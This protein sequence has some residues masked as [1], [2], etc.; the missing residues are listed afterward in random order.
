MDFF[1]VPTATFGVLYVFLVLAHE[2]RKILPF[3]ITEAPSTLWTAQQM[4]E[5]FPDTTPP[6]YLLRDG[7][8]ISGADFVRRAEG[9]GLKQKLISPQSPWQNPTVE[10]L[11]GALRRECL[12]CRIV[13]N[14][15]HLRR[16]L[17]DYVNYYH[18]HRTHRCLDQDCQE[19]R[20]V[21]SPEQGKV[22]EL[23]LVGGLHHRYARQAAAC[24]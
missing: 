5:A 4:V 8:G 21:E 11:I 10:R 12:D 9:M 20:A 6:R 22:I 14:E 23:P 13:L 16:I 19:P 18:C 7:D 17:T 15:E 3:N 2:R 24:A 1:T